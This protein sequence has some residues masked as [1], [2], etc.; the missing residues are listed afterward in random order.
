MLGI[1]R[2]RLGALQI[3]SAHTPL[4]EILLSTRLISF[5]PLR[6][7]MAMQLKNSPMLETYCSNR[8]R[9]LSCQ[10]LSPSGLDASVRSETSSLVAPSPRPWT[11]RF[12]GESFGPGPDLAAITSAYS[13]DN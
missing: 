6:A 13:S 8:S 11:Q 3:G 5:A 10:T 4:G 2:C 1:R 9:L 12:Q 7:L